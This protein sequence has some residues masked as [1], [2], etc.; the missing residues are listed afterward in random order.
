MAN[1]TPPAVRLPEPGNEV[2]FTIADQAPCPDALARPN[3][4]L[5]E[6]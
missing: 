5:S 3:I 4:A 1:R 6:T 2:V